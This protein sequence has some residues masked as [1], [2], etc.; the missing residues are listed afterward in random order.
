MTVSIL[1]CFFFLFGNANLYFCNRG[2]LQSQ[3]SCKQNM[4]QNLMKPKYTSEK[5]IIQLAYVFR[6]HSVVQVAQ[7]VS[8]V[9]SLILIKPCRENG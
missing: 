9:Y 5:N 4:L 6:E 7:V 2:M 1:F 3:A 8:A